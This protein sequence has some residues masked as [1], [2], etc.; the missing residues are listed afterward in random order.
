MKNLLRVDYFNLKLTGWVSRRTYYD[1]YLL[2]LRLEWELEAMLVLPLWVD[3]ICYKRQKK[4]VNKNAF[5]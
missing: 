3:D 1:T 4:N 2:R 5:Q